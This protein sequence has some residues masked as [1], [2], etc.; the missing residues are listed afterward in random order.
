V[1][2]FSP[3]S[4]YTALDL[5]YWTD[6]VFRF[7]SASALALRQ[8][9][10]RCLALYVFPLSFFDTHSLFFPPFSS[11]VVMM[12]TIIRNLALAPHLSCFPQIPHPQLPRN[13]FSVIPV[14]L[15][16]SR[17][18]DIS[19]HLRLSPIVVQKTVA[20]PVSLFSLR[21]NP[22]CVSPAIALRE[23]PFPR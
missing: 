19:S 14:F 7:P 20:P 12:S 16:W 9:P 3:P 23:F 15:F 11:E 6:S 2:A 21:S 5:W 18:C 17:L 4:S 10:S 1:I 13:L 22:T 8:F